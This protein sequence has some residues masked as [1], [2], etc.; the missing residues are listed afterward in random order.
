MVAPTISTFPPRFAPLVTDKG[1]AFG[2][3]ARWDSACFS[4]D[5]ASTM[6]AVAPRSVQA[7][8]MKADRIEMIL[9]RNAATGSILLYG[10]PADERCRLPGHISV[11]D[12]PSPGLDALASD[13]DRTATSFP[14]R[15]G[16]HFATK[17]AAAKGAQ[18]RTTGASDRAGDQGSTPALRGGTRP[19]G[20]GGARAQGPR[21]RGQAGSLPR[22]ESGGAGS[23]GA[24]SPRA[25]RASPHRSR[26]QGGG[27][28]RR[29][30]A[31]ARPRRGTTAKGG[32]P[33]WTDACA[34]PLQNPKPGVYCQAQR[35]IWPTEDSGR[36]SA[37]R[38]RGNPLYRGHRRSDR[39]PPGAAGA[40]QDPRKRSHQR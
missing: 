16:C 15:A 37:R 9:G 26:S 24:P 3:T 25:G 29:R 32:G 27:A 34:R 10:V 20:G 8:S 39:F 11:R 7:R 31:G 30:S 35:S 36:I 22:R 33:S 5:G 21:R 40:R 17:E 23:E 4:P 2:A 19:I 13:R 1:G 18:G 28:R 14:T 38:A 12:P 6:Q